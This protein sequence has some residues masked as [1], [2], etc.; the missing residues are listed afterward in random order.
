MPLPD[1]K[2]R[3]PWLVLLSVSLGLFMVVIDVTILSIALPTIASQMNATLLEVEWTLIV[4]ALA[5]TLLVPF[6]GRVSDVLGRK[7][8]FILGIIVFDVA[9]LLAA[10]SPFITWLIAARL[11]QAVGGALITS[12]VL[13]I[14]T[15]VFPAGKRGAAMGVQ[16]ILMS[17]GASVG[18]VLGG[19]LVGHFGWQAIFLINVPI[20]IASAVFAGII[21]PAMKSHRSLEPIDWL[22][23]GLL[24][25]GLG[26]L[27]LGVTRGPELGW[28]SW[29]VLLPIAIGI[30]SL[31][32]FI[33]WE[34]RTSYP[35]V[36]LSLFKIREFA[37]GQAAGTLVTVA[38]A[39]PM[40][41]FP[42]Y[43][44]SLRGFS[45]QAAGMLMLPLPLMFMVVAPL[46]GKISDRSGARGIATAGL[47]VIIIGLFLMAQITATMP[48]W[49]VL[50]R[51]MVFGA[52]MG[53]FMA[54]NNSSVMSAAPAARRGVASGLLGMFRY[55]GQSLGIAFAG[56]IFVSFAVSGGFALGGLPSPDMIASAGAS[57]LL[58]QCASDAFVN[59]MR[60]SSLFSVPFAL[61]AMF[62][63]MMREAGPRPV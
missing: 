29:P 6:F 1:S 12:N 24:V 46:A 43:W 62:L 16:A 5:L 33:R 19:F 30:T 3:N 42:F 36:D 39:V 54:P 48:I 63:S 2:E 49:Q 60:A 10:M 15:D 13:A 28:A 14:I 57:P 45:P 47:G 11:L 32:L 21:L 35:L 59:G 17:G 38:L 22:G 25:G 53:M 52:G 37:A 40:L 4:Y 41:L 56:T 9:S 20:G 7:R 27:L 31:A 8:L 55:T 51:L 58:T 26:P 18:P 44:Q 34:L 23:A 61:A 50:W